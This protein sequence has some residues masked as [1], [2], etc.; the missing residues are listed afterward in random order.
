MGHPD[1]EHGYRAEE[2]AR[3]IAAALGLPDFVYVAELSKHRTSGTREVGDALLIANG[4][5]A[6]VQVKSRTPG[7]GVRGKA[8]NWAR[9]HLQKAIRQGRGTAN[10]I[11]LAQRRSEPVTVSPVRCMSLDLAIRDRFSVPLEEL[12]V[13]RWLQI[14]II[15]APDAEGEKLEVPDDV[16]VISLVDWQELHRAIRSVTGILEYVS[17]VIDSDLDVPLGDERARFQAVV[18]ADTEHSD[19]SQPT[20]SRPWFSLDSLSDPLGAQLYRELVERVWPADAEMPSVEPEDYRKVIELLD[21]I[22]PSMHV[23]LGHWILG[24]RAALA[25]QGG[26]QSGVISAVDLPPIVY[27]CADHNAFGDV[28]DFDAELGLL[29]AV[30]AEEYQEQTGSVRSALGVGHRVDPEG[31]DYRY[32]MVRDLHE[33][34]PEARAEIEHRFGVPSSEWSDR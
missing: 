11:Q 5:G 13:Q 9:K 21:A 14:V 33:V 23:E 2:Q 26:R 34:S 7:G 29:T 1:A 27:M 22:P 19:A 17:R 31:I 18:D 6:I 10:T 15:D 3:R 24:K 4:H 16:F 25:R 30:R 8:A 28:V 20:T 12:E 32:I